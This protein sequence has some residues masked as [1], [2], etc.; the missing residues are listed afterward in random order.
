MTVAALVA[1]AIAIPAAAQANSVELATGAVETIQ[2]SGIAAPACLVRPASAQRGINATFASTGTNGTVTIDNLVDPVSAQVLPSRITLVLPITC[3]SAHVL[4]L[5][6]A[7]GALRR[8]GA[9][10][11]RSGQFVDELPYAYGLRWAGG[12]SL[13]PIAS[14]QTVTVA[15]SG[16]ASGL[17]E[18]TL[19]VSAGGPLLV[20]GRYGDTIIVELGAAD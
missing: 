2:V 13:L 18:V 10:V 15:A 12:G 7:G 4:R 20:A 3:N 1:L 14:G 8:E 17:A 19:A 16:A 6:S 5:R 9:A 11:T